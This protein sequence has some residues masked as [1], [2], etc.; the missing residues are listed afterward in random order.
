VVFV[1]EMDDRG[2]SAL[3][4]RLR[5]AP[6]AWLLVE[7]H[8]LPLV[9]G[10]SPRVAGFAAFLAERYRVAETTERGVWYERVR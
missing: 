2:W 8:H 3:T 10:G 5:E 6:P 4:A 9:T 1:Q 7:R